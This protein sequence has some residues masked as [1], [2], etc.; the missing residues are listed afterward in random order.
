MKQKSINSI[1]HMYGLGV[2]IP[3]YIVW[4]EN[5]Y[6]LNR[7]LVVV[8]EKDGFSWYDEEE[9]CWSV[10]HSKDYLFM[11]LLLGDAEADFYPYKP[12]V[13]ERYNYLGVSVGK[14]IREYSREWTGCME[15]LA[16]YFC[17]NCF[18][19][20]TKYQSVPT[21][22]CVGLFNKLKNY[23]EDGVRLVDIAKENGEEDDE[24]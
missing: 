3:F 1:L 10:D 2:N 17:G 24:S 20:S 5:D 9:K 7:E 14:N 23:Y 21:G 11:K 22:I 19:Y 18:P 12:I 4:V 16:N 8:T 6:T 15:D 13:G